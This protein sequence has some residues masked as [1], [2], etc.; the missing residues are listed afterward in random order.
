MYPVR[1]TMPKK[2]PSKTAKSPKKHSSIRLSDEDKAI[3]KAIARKHGISE[4]AG[5]RMA[6][7]LQA[8]KDH[9]ALPQ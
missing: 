1:L 3:M 5:V 9:I 6:L 7:R 4:A 8:E 2:A